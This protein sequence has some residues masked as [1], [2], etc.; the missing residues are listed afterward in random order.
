MALRKLMRHTAFSILNVDLRTTKPT[1]CL[2]GMMSYPNF[3]GT[4][5]CL[6]SVVVDWFGTTCSAAVN[7]ILQ[8]VLHP[9]VRCCRR[10]LLWC[11]KT[12]NYLT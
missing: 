4:S 8:V 2:T 9:F 7:K 6:W 1:S 3:G 12:V 5:D 11:F 10:Q